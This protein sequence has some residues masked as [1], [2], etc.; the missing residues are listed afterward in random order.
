MAGMPAYRMYDTP[1]YST[2]APKYKQSPDISVVPGERRDAQQDT[3]SSG[4][5]LLARVFVIACVAFAILGFI[6]VGFAS[7]TVAT[8]ISAN[9]VASDIDIARKEGS[10]LEVQQSYLSNQT[11]VKK[12]ATELGMEEAGQSITLLLPQDIVTTNEQGDLSLALSIQSA[13]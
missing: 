12:S 8:A 13:S 11:Y 4:V 9:E 1:I 7:A 5:L 2:A 10:E 3:L 6:R